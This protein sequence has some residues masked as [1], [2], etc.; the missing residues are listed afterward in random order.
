LPHILTISL[1]AY[2]HV[3]L[4]LRRSFTQSPAIAHV[5]TSQQSHFCFFQVCLK[6]SRYALHVLLTCMSTK[7]L[8]RCVQHESLYPA[9]LYWSPC[10][11]WFLAY[12]LAA[13]LQSSDTYFAR[14]PAFLSKLLITYRDVVVP[15]QCHDHTHTFTPYAV[16]I[17]IYAGVGWKTTD[18]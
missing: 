13:Q 4:P 6:E 5:H 15:S 11:P 8:I 12:P 16:E 18:V 17:D 14:T 2:L 1:L 9:R 7:S 10:T 3:P